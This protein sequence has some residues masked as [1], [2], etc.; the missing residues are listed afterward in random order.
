MPVE[1]NCCAS[2]GAPAANTVAAGAANAFDVHWPMAINRSA[3][4]E[5][6]KV[7]GFSQYVCMC[8]L[9]NH[10]AEDTFSRGWAL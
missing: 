7:E 6:E 9:H 2:G 1:A 10:R 4:N 5:V 8:V 3:P